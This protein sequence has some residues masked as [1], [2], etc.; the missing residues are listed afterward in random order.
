[1]IKSCGFSISPIEVEEVPFSSE[2]LQEATAIGIPDE[3]LGRTVKAF[4]VP[5]DSQ[6]FNPDVLIA[7]C[8]E[9]MPRYMVPQAVEILDELPKTTSGKVDYPALR[10]REGL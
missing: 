4:I 2:G 9:K 1:M 7:Y 6:A 5:R 10:R 3:C 8:A